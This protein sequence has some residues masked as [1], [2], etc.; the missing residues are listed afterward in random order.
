MGALVGWAKARGN[1]LSVA[2]KLTRLRLRPTRRVGR[3]ERVLSWSESPA[4]RQ[5]CQVWRCLL[6]SSTCRG[7]HPPLAGE[8]H[9]DARLSPPLD[10][11]SILAARFVGVRRR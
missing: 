9:R 3:I 4:A 5:M 1:S 10:T 11:R 6:G 2:H 7:V 8:G